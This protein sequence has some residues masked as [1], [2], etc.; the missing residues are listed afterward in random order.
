MKNIKSRIE[1]KI[2]DAYLNR[3]ISYDEKQIGLIMLSK[4]EEYGHFPKLSDGELYEEIIK[5]IRMKS[6][7]NPFYQCSMEEVDSTLKNMITN[8]DK[9]IKMGAT[10]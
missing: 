9:F 7:D 8:S 2:V 4:M 6:E 1:I 5:T 3:E 10:K